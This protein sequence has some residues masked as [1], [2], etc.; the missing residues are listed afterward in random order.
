MC[1]TASSNTIATGLQPVDLAV[2]SQYVYWLDEMAGTVHRFAKVS[3]TDV[4]LASSQGKPHRIAIDAS[5]VYWT[6]FL[7]AA[8]MR[9][10]KVGGSP[11]LVAAASQPTDLRVDD[12]DAYWIDSTTGALRRAPKAGG[13]AATIALP[14]PTSTFDVDVDSIFA[15]NVFANGSG[16]FRI[17][18]AGGAAVEITSGQTAP[19]APHLLLSDGDRV[20]YGGAAIGGSVAVASVLKTGSPTPFALKGTTTQNPPITNPPFAAVADSLYVYWST[21]EVSPLPNP[22]HGGVIRKSA[23]CSEGQSAIVGS[24]SFADNGPSIFSRLAVDDAY[25]YWTTDTRVVRYAKS[26]DSAGSNAHCVDTF[27]DGMPS[28]LETDVDCG[29]TQCVGCGLGLHC[30]TPS[31]CATASI[32]DHGRCCANSCPMCKACSGDGVTCD[33]MAI[34]TADSSPAHPCSGTQACDG[35]GNCKLAAGQPC[36]SNSACAFGFCFGVPAI[37]Q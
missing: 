33:N 13:A 29:G 18:K 20:F 4:T 24:W 19:A 8:V 1:A 10:P 5:Y 23:K 26:A 25:L 17:P 36:S 15:L 14:T 28:G 16:V 37:C 6:N 11:T 2:D 27:L 21:S 30:D 34:G 3:G 22:V 31:D 35:A 12:T 32:C 9:V 7:G